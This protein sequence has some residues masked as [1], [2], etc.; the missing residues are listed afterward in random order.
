MTNTSNIR[1]H[2][3]VFGSCGNRL[4]DV[5]HVEGN[6][7]KLTKNSSPDGQHHFIPMDWVEEVDDKVHLNKNCGE[8]KK[9][10]KAAP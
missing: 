9:E 3:P 2:M 7:I 1:E 10:W 8:A 4:G 6:S 5:D